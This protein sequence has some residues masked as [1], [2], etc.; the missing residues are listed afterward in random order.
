MPEKIIAC[1]EAHWEAYKSDC[2]CFVKAVAHELGANLV[3]V[4]NEISEFIQQLPKIS[5]DGMTATSWANEEKLVVAGL[6]GQ[7]HQPPRSHGHH[8][9]VVAGPLAHNQYPS[10]FWKQVGFNGAK[11][12][13]P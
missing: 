12:S 2:S 6:K 4:T 5:S 10:L 1:C 3:G 11:K 8:V 13:D 9:T 7:D